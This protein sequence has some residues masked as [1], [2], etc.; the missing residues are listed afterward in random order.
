MDLSRVQGH[1][2]RSLASPSL[3]LI[4]IF[5]IQIYVFIRHIKSDLVILAVY[6]NDILLTESDSDGLA[7]IKEYL[8]HHFVTK[9][10]GKLKYFLEIEVAHQ[11]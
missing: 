6:V 7:E 10:M 11:T 9:D 4:F 1:V 8:R 5:V 2:L 3:A